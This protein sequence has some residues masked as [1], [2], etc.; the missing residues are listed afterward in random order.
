MFKHVSNHMHPKWNRTIPKEIPVAVIRDRED[1]H[2]LNI[3]LVPA[4]EVPTAVQSVLRAV[5]VAL[6][7]WAE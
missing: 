5:G 1:V 4:N 7:C 6:T 3:P 2:Q